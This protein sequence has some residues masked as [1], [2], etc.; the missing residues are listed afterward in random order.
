MAKLSTLTR[1]FAASTR[2]LAAVEFAM[3]V[4]VLLVMLLS[5]FDAGQGIAVYMKVRAA[6]FTLG[7]I[8]NQYTTGSNGISTTDMTAIT[9]STAAVLAPFSGTPVVATITQ[10]QA[11]SL[12]AATVSWSYSLNGTAY[13]TGASWTLPT[14]FTSSNACNSFPCYYIYAQVS[15]TYTPMFSSFLTGP[16]TLADNV[17]VTPRSSVCIQYNSVPSS[18]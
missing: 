5:T 15:Y 10:V 2:G 11:T 13:T 14:Q 17:Y 1:R 3:I 9:G 4:P 16:I 6:T 7:S 18:C 8:T 12:T